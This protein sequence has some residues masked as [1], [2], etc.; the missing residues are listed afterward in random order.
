M[1]VFTF[2]KNN[3]IIFGFG[4]KEKLSAQE[5]IATKGLEFSGAKISSLNLS[6]PYCPEIRGG[7][8]FVFG[9][10]NLYPQQ[11][12]KAYSQSVMDANCINYKVWMTSTSFSYDKSA[13]T[14][15]KQITAEQ[16]NFFL[17]KAAEGLVFD[18]F[19]H[20]RYYLEITWNKDFSKII[21]MEHIPAETIRIYN[22]DN[23]MQP[24]EYIYCYDWRYLGRFGTKVYPKFSSENKKD[25]V[26]LFEYQSYTPGKKIYT[27]PSYRSAMDWIALEGQLGIYHNSNMVN[28]LNPSFLIR[29]HQLPDTDEKKE[30][31]RQN[32]VDTFAGA[33]KAG[34]LMA[35]FSPDKDSSPD[36]EQ[37]EPSKLDKGFLGL[38][39]TTQRA[40]C[41]AHSVNADLL[42]L[43]TAGS[44]GDSAGQLAEIKTQFINSIIL[45]TKQKIEAEINY[46][47]SFNGIGGFTLNS[48]I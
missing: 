37:L 48:N 24:T 39:D 35:I 29:F 12:L 30:Q 34:R 18:Y 16:F 28:S 4:K 10:R 38:V 36:I 11:L 20:N 3:K 41:A 47:A 31:V 32:L 15:D 17:N 26:Q 22:V 44:L 9:E 46:L 6:D 27:L 25:N 43:K 2:K 13:M 1:I 5:P 7:N 33:D 19:L 23:K 14:F 40:I 21:K 45:P 42:G 8:G